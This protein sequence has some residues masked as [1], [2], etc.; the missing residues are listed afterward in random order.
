M[1]L[2]RE[3]NPTLIVDRTIRYRMF[4]ATD[5]RQ[6]P[7]NKRCCTVGD[8][9]AKHQDCKE[10]RHDLLSIHTNASAPD[11]LRPVGFWFSQVRHTDA[12][13]QI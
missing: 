13:F 12:H 3:P 5:D 2:K 7:L 1:P 4:G 8:H 9:R 10:D 6:S 11:Y